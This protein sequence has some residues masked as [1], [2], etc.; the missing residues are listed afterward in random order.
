MVSQTVPIQKEII[1]REVLMAVKIGE[2][3]PDVKAEAYVKGSKEAKPVRLSD[4]KG[5]WVVIFF[6]PRDFT[7]VCPTEIQGFAKLSKEFEKEKAAIIGGSTDS[8]WS[9]K[10]WFEG[11]ARLKDV[12]FPVIAD[13]SHEVAE[14]FGVLREK[15]G[16]ALRGTVLID[17]EGIVRHIEVNDVNVGRNVEET[18]RLLQAFRT[19]RLCP[20]GWKPGM[21]HL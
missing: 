13:T 18:L 10:A 3:V 19:G 7:F 11:D 14:A 8:F 6:Y 20:E 17:P 5:R 9:H 21:P 12:E 16:T 1:S 2:P 4:Y 15:D